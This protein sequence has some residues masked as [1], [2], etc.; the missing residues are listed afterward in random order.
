[1]LGELNTLKLA[2]Q[3][4]EMIEK[5]RCAAVTMCVRF[6]SNKRTK[7]TSIKDINFRPKASRLDTN[8]K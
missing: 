4:H 3:N 5:N 7:S 8:P 2:Q 6:S 1:M